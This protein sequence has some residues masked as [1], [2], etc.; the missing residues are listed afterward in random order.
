MCNVLP[1]NDHHVILGFDNN[2]HWLDWI[3][4]SAIKCP[5]QLYDL[6]HSSTANVDFTWTIFIMLKCCISLLQGLA[7]RNWTSLELLGINGRLQSPSAKLYINKQKLALHKL[8]APLLDL[9]MKIPIKPQPIQLV[10]HHNNKSFPPANIFVDKYLAENGAMWQCDLWN[11]P[12]FGLFH[13]S[14]VILAYRIK[15]TW[16]ALVFEATIYI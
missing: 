5:D 2:V 14:S 6:A 12:S 8:K 9:R 1:W 15:I 7:E 10:S 4:S 3:H 11:N 16:L 13:L